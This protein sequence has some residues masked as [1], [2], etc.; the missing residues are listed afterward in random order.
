MWVDEVPALKF[1]RNISGKI[2]IMGKKD[3]KKAY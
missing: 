1:K 3:I 2:Q